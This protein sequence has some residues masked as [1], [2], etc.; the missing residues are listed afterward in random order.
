[1]RN[2]PAI[3]RHWFM[4][5]ELLCLVVACAI[6]LAFRPWAS[7]GAPA[8]RMP[9]IATVVLLTLLWGAQRWVPAGL[10][11][12]L[13]GAC[14]LVLMFGWPLAVWTLLPVAAAG[15]WLAGGGVADAVRLAVW[16]GVLPATL[17]LLLGLLSRR[18][19]PHHLMV[20]V[21]ARGFFATAFALVLAGVLWVA[22][23]PLPPGTEAGTA[24]TGHWLTAFGEA[25]TTGMLAAI[26]VAYRPQWLA[27]YSDARYL[28]GPAHDV[29]PPAG[30]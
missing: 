13:S 28:P 1:M 15:T 14:L 3:L 7:L 19:L 16:T 30:D 27:T 8:L 6:A 23:Q 26:F 2:A 21:L 4:A 10:H 25:F 12:H 9:W 20:Y 18:W 17:A 29:P 22:A 11:V 5:F 24:L